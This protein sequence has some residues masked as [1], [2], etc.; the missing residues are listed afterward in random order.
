MST[1]HTSRDFDAELRELRANLLAMGARCE[2]GVQLAIRAFVEDAP[3]LAK[4]VIELDRR[5]NRDEMECDELALR[6]IALRQPVA[7]DLRLITTALKLVTDL[8]RIGDEAVNIAERADD[9][10]REGGLRAPSDVLRRMAELAEQMLRDALDA[11]VESDIERAN[12]VRTAD[13][14]VDSLYGEALRQ[15]M[16]YMAAHPDSIPS[17]VRSMSVA[18]YLERIADHATNIAEEVIFMVAGQDVRHRTNAPK[19]LPT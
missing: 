17:A 12:R 5:I 3:D 16:D 2:R 4:E 8:E 14:A 1:H 7:D 11:F 10:V 9:L 13:D 19:A 15:M 18:K 6:I